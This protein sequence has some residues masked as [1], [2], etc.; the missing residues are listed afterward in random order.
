M[1]THKKTLTISFILFS[2]H[3]IALAGP[4]GAQSV[5]RLELDADRILWAELSFQ[6]QNL[7]V[8]AFN[9]VRLSSSP[10]AE[11]ETSLIQS[12]KGT[13]LQA[14]NS[15]IHSLTVETTIDAVFRAPVKLFN[16]VWF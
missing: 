9:K 13:P 12:P 7:F 6:A 11:I 3:L 5:T 8:T 10:A 4:I 14:S 15:R 1:T 2:I 16:E